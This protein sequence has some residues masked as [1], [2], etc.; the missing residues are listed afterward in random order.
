MHL[1]ELQL[2]AVIS[3]LVATRCS[4]QITDSFG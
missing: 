4:D 2:E 3:L 1:Q